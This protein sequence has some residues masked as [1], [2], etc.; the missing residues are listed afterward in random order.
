MKQIFKFIGIFLL[1]IILVGVGILAYFHLGGKNHRTPISLVSDDAIFIAE[2]DNVSELMVEFTN[3]DYWNSIL[4]SE[5]FKEFKEGMVSFNEMAS[6][7]KWLHAVL[8]NQKVAISMHQLSKYK[9]DFLMLMDVKKYGKLNL[10]PKI[11]AALKMPVQSNVVDSISLYSVVMDEYDMTVHLATIDNLLIGSLSYQLVEQTIKNRFQEIKDGTVKNN[12]VIPVFRK[13]QLN[14]YADIEKVQQVFANSSQSSFFKGIDFSVLGGDFQQTSFV[15]DGYSS[16]HD[17]VPSLFMPL[18]KSEPGKRRAGKVLPSGAVFYTNFNIDD[19]EAFYDDFLNQYQALDPDGYSAYKSGT[20]LTEAYLGINLKED[21][22]GWMSGEVAMAKLRPSDN[23]RELDFVVA[24]GAKEIEEAESKLNDVSKRLKN[25]TAVRFKQLDYRNH[26]IH[27]LNVSGFFKLVLGNFFQNKEKPYY[28]IID[29]FVVFSNS[30]DILMNVI[31]SYLVGNT[32]QRNASFAKFNEELNEN[33]S[34]TTY[35][36]MHR[37]YEHLYY[38][39]NKN[40]R[41]ELKKYKEMMEK[42]GLVGLQMYPEN[43]FLK[44]QLIARQDTGEKFNIALERL[45]LSAEELMLDE[46]D[47][48]QFKI[49]LG[50]EYAEFDGDVTYYLTHPE[51]VQDSVLVH[52]GKLDDGLSDGMWKSY[53]V[54]GNIESVVPYDDGLVDGTAIFYYDNEKHIIR[55]EMEIDDDVFDGEYKEFYTDGNI[56]A[57]LY[58]KD[59][60]RW[61]DAIF[62]YQNGSVKIKGQFKKGKRNG[63]WKYYSQAGELLKKENW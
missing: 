39:S 34:I 18:M 8:K 58:F 31:D 21:M 46:F 23:A 5:L 47:S 24:F 16:Y 33:S 45:N 15:L 32:L 38:Y 17:S 63:S 22:F 54:S 43:K 61:G 25:R 4:G 12:N 1:A 28:T 37:L 19:V 56:K 50:E 55:A 42:V 30:S 48:L 2:T 59:N 35:V 52:E 3:S 29:D 60:M 40:E 6:D 36:N 7:N 13:H 41:R 57:R 44:T 53:F 10:V 27:Y 20:K 9:S 51:K 49:D 14:I 26:E 62:Y 11:A